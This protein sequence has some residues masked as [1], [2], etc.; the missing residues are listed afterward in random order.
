M[1]TCIYCSKGWWLFTRLDDLGLCKKCREPVREEIQTRVTAYGEAIKVV[2]AAGDFE[3]RLVEWGVSQESL[4][5]LQP[6][7]AVGLPTV[8]PAPSELLTELPAA[9]DG[10]YVEELGVRAGLANEASAAASS[11]DPKIKPYDD[12]LGEAEGFRAHLEATSIFDNAVEAIRIS[13]DSA[14]VAGIAW[15]LTSAEH[16]SAEV[17]DSGAKA[18][19]FEE[20][21]ARA[22]PFGNEMVARQPLD[23]LLA[24][25]RWSRDTAVLDGLGDEL[26]RAAATSATAESASDKA[27]PFADLLEVIA[28]HRDRMEDPSLLDGLVASAQRLRDEA[29][30]VGIE[31]GLAAAVTASEA[32]TNPESKGGCFADLLEQSGGLRDRFTDP[33]L[34]DR[35]LHRIAEARDLAVV[36]GL[37][38]KA[39]DAAAQSD[40]ASGID[41]R[42]AP[43]NAGIEAVEKYREQL[44]FAEALDQL[45]SMMRRSKDEAI[46]EELEEGY[47]DATAQAESRPE[48]QDKLRVID[49]ACAQLEEYV[50]QLSAPAPLQGLVAKLR[51]SRGDTIQ[52]TLQDLA[53]SA[54]VES[55][56]ADSYGSKS[57]PLKEGI[58]M[59]EKFRTEAADPMALSGLETDLKNAL[60]EAET[61]RY[62]GF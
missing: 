26:D 39:R 56:E 15:E 33:T 12:L 50:P 29:L 16:A 41:A 49:K 1:A 51:K 62:A 28:G 38:I 22:E 34:L 44:T 53:E 7:E 5:A 55:E 21:L 20:L 3:A 54:L 17:D 14:L 32:E 40:D 25:I 58:R 46:L 45:V 48:L 47:E 30:V 31:A 8:D 6:F 2:E 23:A 60:A 13:R 57:R 59:M 10:I 27:V 9:R 42:V 35:L 24:E 18:A 37:R 19:P 52:G 36:E 43:L 61:S 11:V 4:E